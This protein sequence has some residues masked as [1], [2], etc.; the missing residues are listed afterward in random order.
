MK[1]ISQKEFNQLVSLCS[2]YDPFTQYID[3]YK[4]EIQAEKYNTALS[5]A[6]NE[7][8]SKFGIEGHGIPYGCQNKGRETATEVEKYLTDNGVVVEQKQKRVWTAEEIKELI[9]TN[10][11]VLYGALK[12]LY[13]CQTADEKSMGDTVES[14]GVGFNGVDAPILSSMAEFL[15]KRG[16]LTDKQKVIVRKKLVKYNKQLTKLANR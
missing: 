4:Q 10:D 5:E 7:V 11:K 14:N 8:I 3:S 16:Y 1:T 15:N 6:F 9:Q 2:Q 12:N 13:A